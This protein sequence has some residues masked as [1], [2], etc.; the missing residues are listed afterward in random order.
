M[1]RQ[2]DEATQS[3]LVAVAGQRLMDRF[4]M[5]TVA[6]LLLTGLTVS[7][8]LEL[9]VL[10]SRTGVAQQVISEPQQHVASFFAHLLFHLRFFF[11]SLLPSCGGLGCT[12]FVLLVDSVTIFMATMALIPK[13]QDDL[14]SSSLYSSL[15]IVSGYVRIIILYTVCGLNLITACFKENGK[16]HEFYWRY[17][18]TFVGISFVINATNTIFEACHGR[19]SPRAW[20]IPPLLVNF[21]VFCNPD[22]QERVQTWFAKTVKVQSMQTSAASIAALVGQG[23]CSAKTALSSASERFRSIRI[24]DLTFEDL[25]DRTPNPKLF[26]RSVPAKLG[27]CDAFVSHSWEDNALAKWEALQDWRAAFL[28]Q[29]KREPAIWLDKCCIDQ[30]NIHEDLRSLPVF[31]AGC[32][33][34]VVLCGTTYLSRLWCIMEL[35]TF[36]HMGGEHSDVTFVPVL[37]QESRSEDL[38]AVTGGFRALDAQNC[39]CFHSEDKVRM[40]SIINKASGDLSDFNKS[41]C[42]IFECVGLFSVDDV[43]KGIFAESSSTTM[44]TKTDTENHEDEQVQDD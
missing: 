28:A 6:V 5:R 36:V 9:L 15:H 26:E 42:K 21:F 32:N 34:L 27:D 4:R 22:F 2:L 10:T 18:R 35:F 13:L 29:H 20:A 19:V 8:F 37:R 39:R 43:E 7:A 30:N 23:K 12:R 31:L 44:K 38:E 11:F 16:A 40:L 24:C 14:A 33:S 41:I 1:E 3:G 25:A 17:V